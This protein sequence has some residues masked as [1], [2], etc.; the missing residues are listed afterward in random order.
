MKTGKIRITSERPPSKRVRGQELKIVVYDEKG[1]VIPLPARNLKLD[2]TDRREY[3]TATMD[4]DVSEIDLELDR[5]NVEFVL[6]GT[7]LARL[8]AEV[9]ALRRFG[10]KD[11]TAMAD[12]FLES[13]TDENT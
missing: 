10:N 4:L 9:D 3:V 7:A 11:C 12:E 13:L 5:T 6:S 1:N 8:E 2:C